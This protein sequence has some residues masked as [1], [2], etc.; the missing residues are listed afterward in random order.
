MAQQPQQSKSD[1][2]NPLQT[3]VLESN[4][5]SELSPVSQSVRKG[6]W[7]VTQ[8]FV[9][10]AQLS[11]DFGKFINEYKQAFITVALIL[12]AIISLRIVLAVI[13][14]LNDIPLLQSTF[15]LIGV[16]YSVWF[17][18]RY[19]LKPSNRQELSQ[20]LRQFLDEQG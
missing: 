18:S 12:A 5:G 4:F 16:A 19:L 14:A 8:V 9:F 17:V 13:D 1:D 2:T 10:L 11:K 3:E 7:I 6:Q 20:T 15:E